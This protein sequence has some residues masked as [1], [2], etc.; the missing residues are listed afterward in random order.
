MVERLKKLRKA[1]R[2]TQADFAQQLN[3]ATSTVTSYETG[4]RQMPNRTI[5]DIC[6][7]FNVNELW[8]RTGEGDMFRAISRDK[9]LA[10]FFG[11]LLSDGKTDEQKELKKRMVYC[12]ARMTPDQ[13]ELLAEI[14]K[15]LSEETEKKE[16]QD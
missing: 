11:E 3:I 13:W 4:S 8:L 9:E 1:L 6:E 14:A 7:K 16:G 12:L 15:A 10:D 2:L 5:I